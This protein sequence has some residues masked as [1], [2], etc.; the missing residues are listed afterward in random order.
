M[1]PNIALPNKADPTAESQQGR[2]VD[3]SM[4]PNETN[5]EPNSHV[6]RLKLLGSNPNPEATG[7]DELPGKSN[8]FIGN[9]PSRWRTGVPSYR[10]V[11][12]AQVYP[13]IDLV[14]YGNQRQLEYD[15]VVAPG[16]DPGQIRLA[17]EGADRVAIDAAGDLVLGTPDGVM[18]QHKPVVYQEIDGERRPLDGRYV[19]LS[20]QTV[21]WAS[22][23]SEQDEELPLAGDAH[24][25]AP[26]PGDEAL[27]IAYV[28]FEVADYDR[29][30]PLVIDPMLAYSTFF[31][32][33]QA[34]YGTG[35]Y[36]DKEKNIYV[37]GNTASLDFP[38]TAGAVQT[39][40]TGGDWY[41]TYYDAFVAKLSADGSTLLYSTYLGG[42]AGMDT[43]NGVSADDEG[44]AY[45]VGTTMS[46]DFP[47]TPGAIDVGGR[48]FVLKLD[49]SGQTLIYSAKVG[50]GGGQGIAI[51]VDAIGNAFVTGDAWGPDILV[52]PGAAQTDFAGGRDA[53]VVKLNP[54]GTAVIY[55]TYIGGAGNEYGLSLKI[56]GSGRTF[57][58]GPTSSNDFPTANPLQPDYAGGSP[59][60]DAFVTVV[61]RDG[62]QFPFS[63]Y[64]GGSGNDV[65]YGVA[66]D[67]AGSV[68]V[69]GV[70][71]S[72]DFPLEA[73]LQATF[74]GSVTGS[75]SGDAFLLKIEIIQPRLLF[76]T[77]SRRQRRR[78]R[79]R[80]RG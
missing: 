51:A 64:I 61:N 31:G 25:S 32:G 11:G 78:R 22:P 49:A 8:Y 37:V 60:G 36:A 27:Q 34:D 59:H 20:E 23:T 4:Q 5:G 63:S 45:V 17:V 41:G 56:D 42:N 71:S 33:N 75:I 7:L 67:A 65:G 58:V 28:G 53:F 18:R 66:V 76:S 74:G 72:I 52:T 73:A 50:A 69:T 44:N 6:L 3:G 54:T 29:E 30:R 26:S 68:Y 21:G 39:T 55:G 24:T 79:F 1:G 35:I 19:L 62:A 80:G 2:L 16:A 40:K 70:T 57:V 13:G 46:T 14:Y 38:I 15:F 10:K 9:D 47:I 77:Y 48:A 12:F 43:A